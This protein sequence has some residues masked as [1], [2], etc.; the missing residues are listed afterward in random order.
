MPCDLPFKRIKERRAQRS[1]CVLLVLLAIR[2]TGDTRN[3][4]KHSTM[5]CYDSLVRISLTVKGAIRSL[6]VL[7][8]YFLGGPFSYGYL[9]LRFFLLSWASVPLEFL[10]LLYLKLGR[11][12]D[13][14]LLFD[15]SNMKIMITNN[16]R[17]TYLL[18]YE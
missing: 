18:S 3:L 7:V 9:M 13:M 1:E 4:I 15:P 14:T 16:K 5:P 2:S 17:F 8:I 11:Y 6:S 10:N 12:R